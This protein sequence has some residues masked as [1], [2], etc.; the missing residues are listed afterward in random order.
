MT[1]YSAG[2]AAPSAWGSS[3]TLLATPSAFSSRLLLGLMPLPAFCLLV[4]LFFSLLRLVTID[5]DGVQIV[6]KYVSLNLT[7]RCDVVTAHETAV[8]VV[9]S[10]AHHFEEAQVQQ[11]PWLSP[12]LFPEAPHSRFVN[13]QSPADTCGRQMLFQTPEYVSLFF[14]IKPGMLILRASSRR[15]IRESLVQSRFRHVYTNLQRK[16]KERCINCT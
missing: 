16:G 10:P 12:E 9:S 8:L 14:G 13:P 15:V 2:C 5:D 6:S 3:S 7:P 11:H 4:L 1:W